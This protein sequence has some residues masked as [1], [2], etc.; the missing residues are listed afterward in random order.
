MAFTPYQPDGDQ[1]AAPAAPVGG[2][3][4]R[5]YIPP[6]DAEAAAPA[7]QEPS[8]SEKLTAPFQT[9][10]ALGINALAPV[11]AAG[12]SILRGTDYD[13]TR[14]K[15]E[16]TPQNPR[17]Q[18]NLQIISN[19]PGLR[20]LGQG[21]E[22]GGKLISAATGGAVSPTA[23]SDALGLLVPAAGK[24]VAP[25]AGAA[26]RGA[27]AVVGA[28]GTAADVATNPALVAARR[29]GI[30]L[31]PSDVRAG[32]PS[33]TMARG[34]EGAEGLI[35]PGKLNTKLTLH[36][37]QQFT[38]AAGEE[39]GIPN[40]KIIAD[41]AL[42]KVKA[43]QYRIY[44]QV[45]Q[46]AGR[47]ALPPELET[48]LQ[49]AR[50]AARVKTT[51]PP[52]TTRTLSLLRKRAAKEINAP[53]A[54]TNELGYQHRDLADKLE[55]QFAAH[56]ESTGDGALVQK[57][58]AARQALAKINDVESSLK[59]GQLDPATLR[60]LRDRK[61]AP[62]TGRLDMIADVNEAFPHITRSSQSTAASG[63]PQAPGTKYGMLQAAKG[64]VLR[65]VPGLKAYTNVESPQFQER[66]FG[67][68]ATPTEQSYFSS[69]GT[70]APETPAFQPP[71]PQLGSGGLDF[72][73]T[74]GVPPAASVNLAR[75]L[76]LM[77]EPVRGATA[78]PEA[79]SM[80][81]AETPPLV[82]GDVNF[83]ASQPGLGDELSLAPSPG[84]TQGMP[85]LAN[86]LA[87][88]LQLEKPTVRPP[89]G[90]LPVTTEQPPKY[91]L[92]K[93]SSKAK[94]SIT[95]NEHIMEGSHVIKV[96][97]GDQEVGFISLKE[98]DAGQLQ[99]KR[100]K[101]ADELQGKKGP[102]DPRY[103]Q[104]L[105]LRAV[106]HADSVGKPLV[107]DKTVTVAQLRAYESLVKKGKIRVQYADPDAVA[108]ALKR[109]DNRAVVKGKGGQPVIT[110]IARVR[111]AK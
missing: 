69:Y 101:V 60:G 20:Q 51:E 28:G 38:R 66:V 94:P 5:P 26:A 70:R 93:S 111:E 36:N 43:P 45:E 67:P 80:L 107:S 50:M 33:G 46:A 81:T 6:R 3:R 32:N 91:A 34:A 97:K 96:S 76:G 92:E 83:R 79:P 55:A 44:D 18:A 59:G 87:G 90:E 103:G 8:L 24:L 9:A 49:E 54:A 16:Y 65:N 62:L 85:D 21:Q 17:A 48:T 73:P 68:T 104:E 89:Q 58:Q 47:V 99:I 57:F 1:P 29:L 82:R 108:A 27:K 42:D 52:S 13:E 77:P 86:T 61:G 41:G 100:T 78:L 106:D 98:N 15:W 53:D 7:V 88:D 72:T 10:A 37:Q 22:K 4:F 31:R 110:A 74:P 25:V 95:D 39:I 40:A 105:I 84:R 35:E 64:A 30:K 14:K 102:D 12:E 71:G 11:A 109:G 2:G 56:L 23:G 19:L 75:D 63:V